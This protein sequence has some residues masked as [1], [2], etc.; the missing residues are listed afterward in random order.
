MKLTLT[1]TEI[2]NISHVSL[3]DWGVFDRD[4]YVI[5]TPEK[6]IIFIQ[7]L[8]NPLDDTIVIPSIRNFIYLVKKVFV[9]KKKKQKDLSEISFEVDDKRIII[10]D[11]NSKFFFYIGY[12]TLAEDILDV[13]TKLEEAIELEEKIKK[14]AQFRLPQEKRKD[15][16]FAMS[17]SKISEIMFLSDND[18][19]IAQIRRDNELYF[20]TIINTIDSKN[21][22]FNFK[23]SLD[24]IKNLLDIEY[25][26]NVYFSEK[27]N[28]FITEFKKDNVKYFIA[29]LV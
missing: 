3:N 25:V 8:K 17:A 24:A 10:E 27:L 14:V 11:E 18:K 21:Q 26:V 7:K 5:S 20:E 12:K 16:I 19:V 13:R 29:S 1:E 28:T 4:S 9:T 22:E 6:S 2:M 15:L 23:L